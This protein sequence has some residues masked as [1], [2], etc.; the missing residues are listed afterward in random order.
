MPDLVIFDLDGTICDSK[1]GIFFSYRH[2][3][4]VLGRPQPTLEEL[5]DGLGGSLQHNIQ[6]IFK[7][8]ND[9]VQ[10]A[11][12][13]YRDEYSLKGESLVVPFDD[14]IDVIDEIKSNN[15]IVSI[16]TLKIQEFA[17]KLMEDWS[18]RDRFDLISG[19]DYEGKL[20]KSDLISRCLQH[21]GIRAEN[22]VMIGDSMDDMNAAMQ[23]GVRF[24]AASYG[25]SL[26]KD[27]CES[28]GIQYAES[29]K[30]ILRILGISR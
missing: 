3:A 21:A 9:E 18:I 13:I 20:T 8:D 23:S 1:E 15:I 6:K 12:L 11:V 5:N 10:N 2:V 29:P 7:L 22:A 19:A 28:K 14:I 25:F 4:D 17:V 27:L 24:I 16:A 26:P 30:D